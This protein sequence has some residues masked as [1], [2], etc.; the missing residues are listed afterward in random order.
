MTDINLIELC[1]ES[2]PYVCGEPC[3]NIP[4]YETEI[5][6]LFNSQE[7]IQKQ[8]DKMNSTNPAGTLTK[9]FFIMKKRVSNKD[10]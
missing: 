6:G 2:F 1:I 8:V 10:Y 9:I 4:F 7:G 5:G 3:P